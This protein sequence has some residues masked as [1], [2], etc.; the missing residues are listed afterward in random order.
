MATLKTLLW[1]GFILFIVAISILFSLQNST[2][3]AVDLLIT[4]MPPLPV[5]LWILISFVLGAL[6]GLLASALA[7]L[8]VRSTNHLLRRK[9]QQLDAAQ[10]KASVRS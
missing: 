6:F 2:P 3:I 7:L 1:I 5:S 9:L 10:N 8:K 4:P